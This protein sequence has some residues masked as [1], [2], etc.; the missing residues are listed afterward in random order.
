MAKSKKK[1]VSLVL[2]SGGARGAAHIG[3]I[4]WLLEHDYDIRSVSGCSIGALVGGVYAADK[5]DEFEQ[6]ISAITEREMFRLMDISWQISGLVKGDRIIDTLKDLVGDRKIE[7]LPIR[8]TAVAS[9]IDGEKEVWIQDG[10][11]FE[12][13]RASISLPLLLTPRERNGQT[14]IDGGV[15]NPVP[16][17]PTFGDSTDL[18]IAVNLGGKPTSP[19]DES[20][21]PDSDD[22]DQSGLRAKIQK[23]IDKIGI[24]SNGNDEKDWGPFEIANQAFDSM[25]AAISRHK[26][27]SYPPDILIEIPRNACGTMEFQCA[28]KMIELGY[29]K[30]ESVLGD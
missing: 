5:L 8:Y 2:G 3:V 23:Y 14:L 10:S 6:W 21:Q 24:G 20:S 15:L 7:E 1:T 13:I 25:Q 9:N 27:A 18:C 30:A 29:T 19:T 12:A 4:R 17:A 26:L 22:E 11:L 16:I 28:K